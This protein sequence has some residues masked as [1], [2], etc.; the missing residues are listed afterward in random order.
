MDELGRCEYGKE[1]EEES[2][3]TDFDLLFIPALKVL[4]HGSTRGGRLVASM[5][6]AVDPAL[7]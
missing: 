5:T 6:M 3:R 1:D 7:V 2:T 4:C